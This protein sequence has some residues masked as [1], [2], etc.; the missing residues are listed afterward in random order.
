MKLLNYDI[1]LLKKETGYHALQIKRKPINFNFKTI[2]SYFQKSSV[3]KLGLTRTQMMVI[4]EMFGEKVGIDVYKK[5]WVYARCV[6]MISESFADLPFQVQEDGV[7]I[8]DDKIYNKF[9]LMPNS[10]D[11]GRDLRIQ[12]MSYYL[13]NGNG[14]HYKIPGTR[15]NDFWTLQSQGVKVIKG[16]TFIEPIKG[17]EYTEESQTAPL[18]K[19]NVL[20]LRSFN[21][22]SRVEGLPRLTAASPEVGLLGQSDVFQKALYKNQATPS[23]AMVT[24]Q[25]LDKD[26]FETLRQH[27]NDEYTG[28]FK[29]G[30]MMLLDGSLKFEKISLTPSDLNILKSD[31]IKESAVSTMMGV[32]IELNGHLAD[33]KN[34]ANYKA[35]QVSFMRDTV[36]PLGNSYATLL[37]REFYPDGKRKIVI[38]ET[39]I[40]E[41]KPTNQDL[42]MQEHTSLNEKRAM[43]GFEKMEDPN[44]DKIYISSGK[45]NLEMINAEEDNNNL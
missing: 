20:H 32:P 38:N 6:N 7:K 28:A 19:D 4:N 23:G 10:L 22:Y 41:L 35:A 1:N 44:M 24:D 43:Q 11:T 40:D 17:Y 34:V 18:D 3:N 9:Q 2:K 30:K 31:L 15:T 25:I 36:L 33:K 13:M 16:E 5:L 37:N 26:D 12:F 27:V 29:A 21:P 42:A 8:E 39:Q 45:Q 14:Y